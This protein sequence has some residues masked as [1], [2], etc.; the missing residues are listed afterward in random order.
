ML[1]YLCTVVF[2]YSFPKG[3]SQDF[4]DEGQFAHRE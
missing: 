4:T 2:D 1:S 3:S